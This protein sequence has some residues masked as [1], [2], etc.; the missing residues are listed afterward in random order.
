MNLQKPNF[1]DLHQDIAQTPQDNLSID[2]LGPYNATSQ[3]NLYALTAV[4]NLTGYLMTTP[5]KDKKMTS[6]ATH[7][8]C[9]IML[10]FGFLKILHSE[11]SA[12]FKCKLM[13]IL[14]QEL[15]ARKTFIFSHHPQANRKIESSHRFTK[16]CTWK[17]SVD[18]VLEWDQLL[19]Y[20]NSCI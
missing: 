2:L 20:V 18:H 14:S 8:Y 4:C 11:N 16:D 15:G 7:L 9:D 10:K 3:G 19:P 17:L 6:V 13:E 5:I 1:I 12:E